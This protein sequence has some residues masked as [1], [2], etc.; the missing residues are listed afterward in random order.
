MTGVSVEEVVVSASAKE[1][2]SSRG[3][4]KAGTTVVEF[5]DREEPYRKRAVQMMQPMEM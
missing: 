3:W 2:D 5:F 1:A 4:N